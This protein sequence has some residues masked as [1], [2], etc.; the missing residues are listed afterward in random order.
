M[1]SSE[2][3]LQIHFSEFGEVKKWKPHEGF[4]LYLS[5]PK[6]MN[7]LLVFN[8]PP[9]MMYLILKIRKSDPKGFDLFEF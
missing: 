3:L 2:K 1:F 6:P 4:H 5:H 9:R 7:A 8:I